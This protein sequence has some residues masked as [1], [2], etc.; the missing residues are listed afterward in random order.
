M[1]SVMTTTET[2]MSRLF[3]S[4]VRNSVSWSRSWMWLSVGASLNQKG[5][6]VRL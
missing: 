2:P 6:P 4:Q 5:T 3:L 1:T